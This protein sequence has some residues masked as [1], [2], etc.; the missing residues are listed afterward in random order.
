MSNKLKVAAAFLLVWY[1]VARWMVLGITND[2]EWLG[3]SFGNF[4]ALVSI[5]YLVY[6]I[7]HDKHSIKPVVIDA[8][9]FLTAVN[10]YFL[11][12]MF[13]AFLADKTPSNFGYVMLDVYILGFYTIMLKSC[14]MNLHN[15]NVTANCSGNCAINNVA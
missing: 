9:F 11:T 7:M 14:Y 10:A 12:T 2:F 6:N 8:T 4:I 5:V 3:N 1:G 15:T 13:F